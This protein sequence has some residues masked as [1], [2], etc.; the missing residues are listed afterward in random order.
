MQKSKQLSTK[1]VC[2]LQVKHVKH[3]NAEDQEWDASSRNETSSSGGCGAAAEA[4]ES[5]LD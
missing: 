1:P 5:V 4:N 2:S 3:A